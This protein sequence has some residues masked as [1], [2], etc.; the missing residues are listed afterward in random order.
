MKDHDGLELF[1]R[2]RLQKNSKAA[3]VICHG[4]GEHSGRY[5]NLYGP[6]EEESY[7]W[8]ALDHRGHGRSGGKKGCID[9]WDQFVDGLSRLVDIVADLEK[10]KKI[11]LVGHSMGGLIAA[12]YALRFQEKIHA[13]ILSGPLFKL[14]LE[15][16]PV[17]SA[18]GKLIS[19]FVPNF[20]MDNGID[21][22][23]ISHDKKVVDAYVADPLVH[24]RVSA[25]LFTEMTAAMENSLARAGILRLPV[26]VLHGGDDKLTHPEGSKIF[27]A[28]LSAEDKELKI[29]DGFF[30][31]IMNEVE[32]DRVMADIMN[33]IGARS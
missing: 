26:L 12:Q 9:A 22:S 3:V 30:H 31:E 28:N 8:F 23:F 33:W 4:M 19:S 11:F 27:F 32:K 24:S 17:K 25:R 29:Y 15:V 1:Y 16:N 10:G 14:S 5:Q 18:A 6:L 20:T 7:S 13:L 2:R 21:P